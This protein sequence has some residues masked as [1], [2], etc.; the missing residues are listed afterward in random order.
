MNAGDAMNAISARLLKQNLKLLGPELG[1]RIMRA[2]YKVCRLN[3][4]VALTVVRAG[5]VRVGDAIRLE[6]A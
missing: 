3:L 6:D 1:S 2:L 5:R 4:G